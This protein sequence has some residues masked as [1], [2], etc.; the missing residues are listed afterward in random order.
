M[1]IQLNNSRKDLQ[2]RLD[3]YKDVLPLCERIVGLR[4]GIGELL[5]FDT[6]VCEKAE[7]L[8]LPRESAA[9]RV[10]EDIGFYDK[11][12]GMRKQL[13]NISMQI[14]MMNQFLGRQNY[15]INALM[16]LQ[17]YGITEDQILSLCKTIET[18]GAQ[19]TNS[20]S[21]SSF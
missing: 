1:E 6:A 2:A 15:A 20:H 10:I 3:R 4:I 18:N 11:L 9:Y 16:I 8:N 5:A 7:M 14:F 12:G 13:N 21:F 17:F 19:S